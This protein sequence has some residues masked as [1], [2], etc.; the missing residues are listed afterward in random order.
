MT[1]IGLKATAFQV[2]FEYIGK[3]ATL[4]LKHTG[5]KATLF[6]KYTGKKATLFLLSVFYLYIG[7]LHEPPLHPLQP[8][9]KLPGKKKVEEL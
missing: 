3:K 5:K 8:S 4:F 7:H 1:F 2:I 6:K 9:S